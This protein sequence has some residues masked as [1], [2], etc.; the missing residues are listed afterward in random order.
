MGGGS[1]LR[2]DGDK[3]LDNGNLR[4]RSGKNHVAA[5]EHGRAGQLQEDGEN[6]STQRPPII[7]CQ[8]KDTREDNPA[9]IAN[10][11]PK[12]DKI[13]ILQFQN[14]GMDKGMACQV[15]MIRENEVNTVEEISI[16]QKV[17]EAKGQCK[18]GEN[19][20]AVPN[21]Y[22]RPLCTLRYVQPTWKRTVGSKA[23]KN[24][25]GVAGSKVYAKK[26][27][28][29]VEMEEESLKKLKEEHR[30]EIISMDSS[31]AEVGVD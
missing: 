25:A 3:I 29:H 21:Q 20:V 18:A 19:L 10:S 4:G 16:V 31:M 15:D 9:I 8:G 7:Q 2:G 17:S 11:N 23:R 30:I 28:M 13:E 27:H 12:S 24:G 5:K 26:R 1:T 22:E 14:L 6:M